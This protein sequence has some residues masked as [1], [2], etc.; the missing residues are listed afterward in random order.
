MSKLPEIGQLATVKKEVTVK[1]L[2]MK[3]TIKIKPGDKLERIFP[4]PTRGFTFKL[5]DP[6]WAKIHGNPK[7]QL[8]NHQVSIL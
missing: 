7:F 5:A 2:G 8:Y 1:V 3:K 6:A 4:D